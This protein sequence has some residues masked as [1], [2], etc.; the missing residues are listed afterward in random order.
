MKALEPT[1]II[2]RE[3]DGPYAYKTRVSWCVVE[4]ELVGTVRV[5]GYI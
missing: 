2:H 3:G 5:A 1:K 4:P